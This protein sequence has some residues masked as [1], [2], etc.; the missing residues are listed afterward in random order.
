MRVA[1][2][3]TLKDLSTLKLIANRN[4]YPMLEYFEQNWSSCA[5]WRKV[6]LITEALIHI[7]FDSEN[8]ADE[9]LNEVY[10]AIKLINALRSSL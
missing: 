2:E 1:Q 10:E 4:N 3:D 5:D 9:Q 6:E 8:I 7:Y